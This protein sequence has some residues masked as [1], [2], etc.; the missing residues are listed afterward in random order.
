MKRP[1]RGTNTKC[2]K[3]GNPLGAVILIVLPL[4]PMLCYSLPQSSSLPATRFVA[5]AT[6]S[7][8]ATANGAELPL[9]AA[10]ILDNALARDD[11]AAQ[12]LAQILSRA[13]AR[14]QCDAVAFAR[15]I[16]VQVKQENRSRVADALL[17]A[18]PPGRRQDMATMT[19][20]V[21]DLP[22][23]ELMSTVRRVRLPAMGKE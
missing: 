17:A 23:P 8:D 11:I 14:K 10:R 6:K 18:T 3:T 19:R 16:Y 7:L 9:Q 5:R 20:L 2:L 1:F 21:N 15:S 22:P 4:F 12:H 13:F